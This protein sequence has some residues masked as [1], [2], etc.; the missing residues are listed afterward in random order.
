[1]G[2]REIPSQMGRL[3]PDAAEV[4]M[5]PF[6]DRPSETERAA[7]EA[8]RAEQVAAHEAAVQRLRD[9]AHED[10]EI[11][12]GVADLPTWDGPTAGPG[13]AATR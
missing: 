2:V 4:E 11:R 13:P 6:W 5:F 8:A 7:M 12:N 9:L 10:D 3:H 1:M